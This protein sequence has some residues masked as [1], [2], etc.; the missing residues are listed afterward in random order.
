MDSPPTGRLVE[1]ILHLPAAVV[2]VPNRPVIPNQE[3]AVMLAAPAEVI[4]ICGTVMAPI[5]QG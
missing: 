1:A 3:P 2:A 5:P 4:R